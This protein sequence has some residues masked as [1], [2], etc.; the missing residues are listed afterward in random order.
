MALCS[1]ASLFQRQI[2]VQNYMPLS[3]LLILV[4]IYSF[5]MGRISLYQAHTMPIHMS[6]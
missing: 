4:S 6:L 2:L 3:S 1:L 5:S